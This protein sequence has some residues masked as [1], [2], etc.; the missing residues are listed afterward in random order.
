MSAIRR[1][2]L[3]FKSLRFSAAFHPNGPGIVSGMDTRPLLED[4]FVLTLVGRC[5][6]PHSGNARPAERGLYNRSFT[7][8]PF[9]G[10]LDDR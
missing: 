6:A 5:C 3:P 4:C 8:M 9:D 10:A 1:Q 2:A 7:P